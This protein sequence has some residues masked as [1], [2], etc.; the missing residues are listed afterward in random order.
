MIEPRIELT[1]FEDRLLLH[2]AQGVVEL[3]LAY[4]IHSRLIQTGELARLLA[5]RLRDELT[6]HLSGPGRAVRIFQVLQL[7]VFRNTIYLK[8]VTVIS[9]SSILWCSQFVR[10]N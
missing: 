5:E 8:D 7:S 1:L 10:P 4:Q 6:T 2:G 9:Y 3:P